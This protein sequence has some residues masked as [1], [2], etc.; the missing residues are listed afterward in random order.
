MK[1]ITIA[2]LALS[3]GL[4]LTACGNSAASKSEPKLDAKSDAQTVLD[5]MY[6]GNTS[7][8]EQVTG[9]TPEDIEEEIVEELEAKQTDTLI[10]NGNIND[11]F[12]EVDG[13]TYLAPEIITEYAQAYYDQISTIGEAEITDVKSSGNSVKVTAEITP[14]AGLSEANPI[15]EART[16]LFGGLDNDTIIRQSGN[17]EV[18]TIQRLITLKLYG[19]YYGQMGKVAEKAP[20]KE[21]VTFTMEKEDGH[22]TVD[23]ST[24]LELAKS[25]RSDTY[26]DSAESTE[27]SV[28]S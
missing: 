10:G 7:G 4:L 26:A 3:S 9:E 16:E 13:S 1:K 25:S 11:Y 18:E 15:G 22:Y 21:T 27:S 14:I 19:M 23:M 5:F 24:I 8:I 17:K 2:T 6:D 20:E 28:E 12:L